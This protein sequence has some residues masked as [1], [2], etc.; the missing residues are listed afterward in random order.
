MFMSVQSL[1]QRSP[2]FISTSAGPRRG[3]APSAE[4][5]GVAFGWASLES[6]FHHPASEVAVRNGTDS[7][8]QL[9]PR[10]AQ[11]IELRR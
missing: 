4:V 8:R 7:G 1:P 6:G 5:G 10:H 9:Q 3:L 11:G 2:S